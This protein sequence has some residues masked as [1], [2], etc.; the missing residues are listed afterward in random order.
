[1]TLDE[2]QK[3]WAIDCVIEDD[4]GAAAI[5]TPMLHSYY[6]NELVTS[7]LKLTKTQHELAELKAAKARYFRGEMTKP[8]L[9]ERGWP[10]W[11]HRSLKSD[12]EG[13]LEADADCQKILAR[14]GYMKTMIYF[15][16]SVLGEIKNRNWNVRA[17]LDW[18]KWRSGA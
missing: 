16:E 15:L 7:K 18:Q 3:K 6:L 8:E 14:E 12:I 10:Q 9:E 17:S 2:L 1:M 11:Q 13:M 4:L 5:R